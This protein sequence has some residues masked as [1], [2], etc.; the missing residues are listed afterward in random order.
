MRY[1]D[2]PMLLWVNASVRS[3]MTEYATVMMTPNSMVPSTPP[4]AP[5]TVFLGLTLGHSL[6]LPKARPVK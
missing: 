3:A 5:S 1:I 4:T 2:T 6:C